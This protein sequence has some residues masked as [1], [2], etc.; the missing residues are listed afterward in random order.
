MDNNPP[1]GANGQE[2]L[3]AHEEH[4]ESAWQM[5]VFNYDVVAELFPTMHDVQRFPVGARRARRQPIGYGRFV[6]A[7]YAIRFAVE[8]LP[9]ELLSETCLRADEQIFDSDEIR[10]LYESEN[11]PFVRRTTPLAR[12]VSNILPWKRRNR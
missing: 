3:C 1:L 11:Y 9:A 4:H 7:A 6:R 8:E 10:Q 5:T 12:R 2:C